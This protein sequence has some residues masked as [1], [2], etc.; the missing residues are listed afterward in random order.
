MTFAM[1]FG[2]QDLQ[3][4]IQ[5]LEQHP[6]WKS[7]LRASLLGDELL[8][9]P[10][11]VGRLE[12]RMDRVEAALVR[13]AEAQART[14]QRVEELAEAQAR[15]EQR[16]EELAEAQARTEQRVEELAEAQARTEQAVERLAQ[17]VG[18][19]SDVVGFTLEELARELAP[20]YLAERYAIR[21]SSLERQFF[22]LD[23]EEVEID[24]YGEGT[25]DGERVVVI[26]EVRSRIYGR[27][28]ESLAR[29]AKALGPQLTGTPVPAM[30]GFVIHP[31]AREVASRTGALVIA[32][33]GKP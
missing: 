20:A 23:G 12:E 30:F 10:A 5:V 8:Q 19:L 3:D 29:K 27:D 22:I 33:T 1:A 18:R 4:L 6:E 11:A 32:A 26:G 31:S 16:V 25:R 14:E 9:L 24:F 15:T 7:L 2:V 28:V 21:V 13:L 17:Q